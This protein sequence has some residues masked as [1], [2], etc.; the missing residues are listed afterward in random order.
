VLVDV[1]GPGDV[2]EELLEQASLSSRAR[3]TTWLVKNSHT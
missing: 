2:L 3:P 1:L